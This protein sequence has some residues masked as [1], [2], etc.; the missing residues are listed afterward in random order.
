VYSTSDIT[1]DN[2]AWEL[3]SEGLALTDCRMLAYRPADGMVA[4]ATGGRGFFSTDI[5][6]KKVDK[7]SIV[8]ND[9]PVVTACTDST[10]NVSFR[11][12]GNYGSGNRYQVILSGEDGTF[13]N[14]FLIGTGTSS[15]IRVTIPRTL[16]AT[17]VRETA[18]VGGNFVGEAKY[19]IKVV[20][21]QPAFESNNAPEFTLK[22]IQ[23]AYYG[24][25]TGL[26]NSSGR[27]TIAAVKNKGARF[28][29]FRNVSGV[30]TPVA[31]ASDSSII[32]GA[33]SYFFKVYQNGCVLQSA[34]RTI[35]NISGSPFLQAQTVFTNDNIDQS[36]VGKGV[37]LRSPFVDTTNFNYRWRK[38]TVDISN[39]KTPNFQA[40]ENGT[41]DVFLDHKTT[42]CS[43]N[44]RPL[45]IK[46]K[47]LPEATISLTGAAEVKYGN[48]TTV[49]L[50]FN[51]FTLR[52]FEVTLS[53]NQKIKISDTTATVTVFPKKSG[54][55]KVTSVTNACGT[56]TS[57][58][59][60]EIKVIPLIMNSLLTT[61]KPFYC[62]NEEVSV[63]FT[64]DGVPEKDNVY[65]VQ[66]SDD[67]GENFKTLTTVGSNSPLKVI[68]PKE[69]KSGNKYRLR[70]VASNPEVIGKSTADSLNIK[71]VAVATVLSKD[72]SIYKTASTKVNI[73]LTGDAPWT[74]Q[75][76]D[77]QTLT[78]QAN[79]YSV[80]LTP[81]ES[82]VFSLKSVKDNSCGEG[83]VAGS[84]KITVLAPLSAEEDANNIF[85]VFPNPTE[86]NVTITLKIPSNKP[87]EVEMIDLQGKSVFKTLMKGGQTSEVINMEKLPAGT[88]V[89]HAQ[90][91]E[92]QTTKKVVKIK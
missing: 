51:S 87:T 33:G 84:A 76:A 19:K 22:A 45:S 9:L 52:P 14:E 55:F 85:N 3:S 20:A 75:T 15:P 78:A 71:P 42:G 37:N 35:T 83:F 48:S 88:Y 65:T 69:T 11:V 49:D 66:L 54:V 39:G 24:G 47:D 43:Y 92:K 91:D 5:F 25:Y 2:P 86:Y 63:G 74:L 64:I 79:P 4:V 21:T 70:V 44:Y 32:V 82:T 12:T 31:A 40:G 17:F 7:G 62:A 58:G 23:A 10:F 59:E 89:I 18:N 1:A 8:V 50:K 53:D 46:L 57:K 38:N 16:L 81:T 41:Y 60:P 30:A 68:L 73:N 28:E 26:C 61:T 6:A 90:Q 29:W 77:N 80:T 56:G 13:K 27:T 36:C 34:N 72:T 67:K